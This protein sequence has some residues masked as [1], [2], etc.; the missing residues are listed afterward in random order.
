MYVKLSKMGQRH[1]VPSEFSCSQL[2]QLQDHFGAIWLVLS[3]YGFC[4]WLTGKKCG[5][6]K[7]GSTH[8][9]GEDGI[10]HSVLEESCVHHFLFQQSTG[11][12]PP[13]PRANRRTLQGSWRPNVVWSLSLHWFSREVPPL[14]FQPGERSCLLLLQS[15]PADKCPKAKGEAVSK[16]WGLCIPSL[17]PHLF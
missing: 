4:S 14:W 10:T 5:S 13:H 6:T 16:S 11:R 9:T 2:K 3:T 12:I 17:L 15:H 7:C 8:G 1:P